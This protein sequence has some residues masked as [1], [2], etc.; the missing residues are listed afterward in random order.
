MQMLLH[1]FKDPGLRHEHYMQ[2]DLHEPQLAQVPAQP[3]N[4][5]HVKDNK[6]V[7]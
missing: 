4:Q 7:G 1:Q 2:H 5:S 3:L 6:M